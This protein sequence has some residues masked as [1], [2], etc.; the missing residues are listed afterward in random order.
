[1]SRSVPA[2]ARVRAEVY[3]IY[4]EKNRASIEKKLCFFPFFSRFFSI[5]VPTATLQL[6]IIIPISFTDLRVEE[7]LILYSLIYFF[8]EAAAAARTFST[9][10]VPI[11]IRIKVHHQNHS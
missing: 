1:M 4:G 9:L 2:C 6:P 3:T 11:K 8:P 7:K 5:F 10:S